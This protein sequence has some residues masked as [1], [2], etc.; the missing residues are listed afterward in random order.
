M[1]PVKDWR[2]AHKWFSVQGLALLTAAPLLYASF[3]E[4]QAYLPPKVF[5]ICM[6]ALAF[7]TILGR[8]VKQG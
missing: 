8:L 1:K 5:S 4:M 3:S 6:G 7:L 2:K